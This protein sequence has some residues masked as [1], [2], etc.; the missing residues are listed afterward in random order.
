MGLGEACRDIAPLLSELDDLNALELMQG[1]DHS[2][3]TQVE[4]GDPR[5]RALLLVQRMGWPQRPV[6]ERRL[7][8]GDDVRNRA[9]ARFSSQT[10]SVSGSCLEGSKSTSSRPLIGI[11]SK[12]VS[13]SLEPVA[14]VNHGGRRLDPVAKARESAGVS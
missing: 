13:Y 3:G 11:E 7:C 14:L 10:R 5:Q 8:A 4:R 2:R 1:P 12:T 9:R 6:V